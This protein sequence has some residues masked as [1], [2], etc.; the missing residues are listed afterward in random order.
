[1]IGLHWL[2]ASQL[3]AFVAGCLVGWLY[4]QRQLSAA[5]DNAAA[6][7]DAW[8]ASVRRQHVTAAA[9]RN[10]RRPIPAPIR[11]LGVSSDVR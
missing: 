7:A 6:E 2:F 1:M 5:M 9:A 3:L 8:Q 11:P 10:R 4:R